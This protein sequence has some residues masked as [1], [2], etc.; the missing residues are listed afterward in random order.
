MTGSLKKKT[1]NI[2]QDLL[3]TAYFKPFLHLFTRLKRKPTP[4]KKKKKE[5]KKTTQNKTTFPHY[6]IT[7]VP[8]YPAEPLYK[9]HL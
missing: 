5:Q 7:I 1:Q 4:L 2:L 3:S 9:A 8:K 6:K